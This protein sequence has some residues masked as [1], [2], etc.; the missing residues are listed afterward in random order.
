MLSQ[1][2]VY[3]LPVTLEGLATVAGTPETA[4]RQAAEQWRAAAL[5][6]MDRSGGRDLWSVYGM[7]R[8]WLLAPE[9]LALPAQQAARV[10]A[11]QA[12]AMVG[13]TITAATARGTLSLSAA[14]MS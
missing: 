6:H 2:A 13:A 10:A 1:V 12:A 14:A 3:G 9:R 4:V 5:V 11:T 8:S 7:L